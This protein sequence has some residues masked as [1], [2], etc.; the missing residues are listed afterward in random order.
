MRT[1]TR[2]RT[3]YILARKRI[4]VLTLKTLVTFRIWPVKIYVRAE[5]IKVNKN[6]RQLFATNNSQV[7]LELG[8]KDV[9]QKPE[10]DIHVKNGHRKHLRNIHMEM[11]I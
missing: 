9:R 1:G 7:L 5:L 4:I 8:T 6:A 10:V 2:S 11:M 3:S